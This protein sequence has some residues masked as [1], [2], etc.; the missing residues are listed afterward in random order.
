MSHIGQ[1]SP[2]MHGASCSC[3]K[4]RFGASKKEIGR[5]NEHETTARIAGSLAH[6][7]DINLA[8]EQHVTPQFDSA[9]RGLLAEQTQMLADEVQHVGQPMS[10]EALKARAGQANKTHGLQQA[11]LENLKL[12]ASAGLDQGDFILPQVEQNV[13]EIAALK[14]QTLYHTRRKP[15]TYHHLALVRDALP[16]GTRVNT[17]A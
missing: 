2:N 6:L 16:K 3:C 14:A 10:F 8:T 4:N 13:P 15:G 5:Q 17:Q 9:R 11:D 12:L 7:E 1:F